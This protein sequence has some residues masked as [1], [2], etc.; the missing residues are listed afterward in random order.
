MSKYEVAVV[1]ATG[2]VGGT[3][4]QVLEQR[5]FPVSRVRALA[6]ARSAG[7]KIRWGG[8]ELTVE[9]V[10]TADF[11]GVKVALFAGGEI[12]SSE[13]APRAVEHGAVV[14]DN[15]ATYRMDPDVPL[16]VPEVNPHHLD[17][18]RGI[19]ANP[20][21]STIQMVVALAP[22]HKA[23]RL[24][25]VAVAT[26]QSVSGTGKDAIDELEAQ[27]RARVNG[28][29]PPAP[30]AY[31][32]PIAFN[33]LPQI[34]SF[35]DDGFTGEEHKMMAETRKILGEPDLAVVATC[36]RVPVFYAHSEVVHVETEGPLSPDQAREILGAAPGI[37]LMDDPKNGVYPTPLEAEGRDDVL[38]GRIRQDPSVPHGL[39]L[40]VV[41]DNLR[42]GAATNAVQ[43]AEA[44]ERAGRLN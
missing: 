7:T 20:N 43:I 15:S 34:A 42:K 22:L 16:V 24:K 6:S 32:R 30:K 37:T 14:I 29:E 3:M 8:Q 41:A 39:V 11:S 12:A 1:G 17:G 36:I 25:R 21:C 33:L 5:G 40:W 19:I 9:D 4:L 23:V 38:V 2:A 31:P 13:Y 28:V 27:V 26:Y 44:L 35:A 10:A 18:H